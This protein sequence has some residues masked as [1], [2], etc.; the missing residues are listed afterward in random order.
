MKKR[1]KKFDS[2]AYHF[3]LRGAF[4]DDFSCWSLSWC[5]KTFQKPTV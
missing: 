2:A 4:C 1:G 3:R 5:S